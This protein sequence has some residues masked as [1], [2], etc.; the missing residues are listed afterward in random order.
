MEKVENP[1][2]TALVDSKENKNPKNLI[3]LEGN[4]LFKKNFGD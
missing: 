2:E 3:S 4:K 1:H